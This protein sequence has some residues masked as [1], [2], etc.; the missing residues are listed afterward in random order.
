MKVIARIRHWAEAKSKMR[1]ER[2]ILS[3]LALAIIRIASAKNR[4]AMTK[5]QNRWLERIHPDY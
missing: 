4:L 3:T 5:I 1:F 2:A